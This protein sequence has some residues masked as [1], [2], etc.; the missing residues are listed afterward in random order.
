MSFWIVKADPG[1]G[2]GFWSARHL[3]PDPGAGYTRRDPEGTM[4]VIESRG[5]DV[6]IEV[7]VR[8]RAGRCRVRGV[9][10]GRLRIEVTSAPEG[11]EATRQALATLAEALG[12][13]GADATLLK[14]THHRHKT[15]RVTGVSEATCLAR[16]DLAP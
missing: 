11:G 12:V 15:V 3:C 1:Q 4:A 13:H 16:L 2:G 8:P 10:G 14:G 7:S 6:V 5:D 9:S